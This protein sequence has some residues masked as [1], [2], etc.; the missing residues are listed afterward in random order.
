MQPQQQQQLTLGEGRVFL[1]F[2]FLEARLTRLDLIYPS[3]TS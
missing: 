3:Q 1:H 2:P